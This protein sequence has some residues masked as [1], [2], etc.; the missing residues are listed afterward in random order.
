MIR[1]GPRTL[2]AATCRLC[3]RFKP[4]SQFRRFIR[5]PR[6]RHAYWD[7]RCF[8]C[9]WGHNAKVKGGRY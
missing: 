4:A 2:L 1:V 5:N 6:D 8:N 9:K 7:L 3:H